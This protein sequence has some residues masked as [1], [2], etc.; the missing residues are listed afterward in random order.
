MEC[1]ICL[2]SDKVYSEIFNILFIYSK[3]VVYKLYYIK[4]RDK[5]TILFYGTNMYT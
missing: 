5:T 1:N 2:F 3:S 4:S